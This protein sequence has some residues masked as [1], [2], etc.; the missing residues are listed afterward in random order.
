MGIAL[1]DVRQDVAFRLWR[2]LDRESEIENLPSYIKRIV[3]TATIDAMRVV[4]AR[5][6]IPL[7]VVEEQGSD[8]MM[9]RAQAVETGASP[10]RAAETA[11]LMDRVGELLA[12]LPE[13]RCL[14]V[15]LYFQG[16]N[17]Q[18]IADLCG[19]SE[20]KARNLLY[21]GLKRL[22]EDLR[23]AGIVYAPDQGPWRPSR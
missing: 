21:R 13:N 2:A 7:A 23:Q 10:E 3:V 17:S 19:W 4:R 9:P 15:R 20:P 1:E 11:E 16:F 6:E 18:E 8:V 5:R 12:R 22:R 14:A